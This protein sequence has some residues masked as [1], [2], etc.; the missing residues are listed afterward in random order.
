MG[1]LGR[2]V[3]MLLVVRKERRR[4]SNVSKFESTLKAHIGRTGSSTL[5]E[6]ADGDFVP[7]VKVLKHGLRHLCIIGPA[8]FRSF[9]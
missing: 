8:G 1:F 2:L 3:L 9:R 4:H 5:P 6:R 7:T